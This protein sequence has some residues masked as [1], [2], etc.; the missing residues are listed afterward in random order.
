[1]GL[2]PGRIISVTR[3]PDSAFLYAAVNST[4][5]TD[6]LPVRPKDNACI[7]YQKYLLNADQYVTVHDGM[8]SFYFCNNENVFWVTL[9]D[10]NGRLH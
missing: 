6:I 5:I 10:Y 3:A 7:C 8:F 4:P 9:G 2:Y 1:M